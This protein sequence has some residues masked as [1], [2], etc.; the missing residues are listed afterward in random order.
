[1]KPLSDASEAIMGL[2]SIAALG[3]FLLILYGAASR[4]RRAF[5]RKEAQAGLR[6]KFAMALL[7]YVFAAGC[8]AGFSVVIFT[9]FAKVGI[10]STAAR[11]VILV[12]ALLVAGPFYFFFFRHLVM[13]FCGMAWRIALTLFAGP[14][15]PPPVKPQAVVTRKLKPALSPASG[16]GPGNAQPQTGNRADP[17]AGFEDILEPAPKEK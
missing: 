6:V 17:L 13:P 4:V 11:L 9:F 16:V 10:E 5:G 7:P 12:S 8:I 15:R 2:F 3:F 1:M 14:A